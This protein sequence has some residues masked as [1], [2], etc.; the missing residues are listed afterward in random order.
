MQRSCLQ[1][2]HRGT[3]LRLT[4]LF[5]GGDLDS[6]SAAGKTLAETE[7]RLSQIVSPAH[8]ASAVWNLLGIGCVN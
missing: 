5:S 1:M 3:F 8:S 4:T 2:S 6:R 7:D